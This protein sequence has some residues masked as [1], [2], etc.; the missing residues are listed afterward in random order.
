MIDPRNPN[1]VVQIGATDP[2]TGLPYGQATPVKTTGT[3][4]IPTPQQINGSGNISQGYVN[5]QPQAKDLPPMPDNLYQSARAGIANGTMTPQQAL[6]YLGSYSSQY[7]APDTNKLFA[8]M[9]VNKGGVQYAL[10]TDGSM[11]PITATSTKSDLNLGTGATSITTSTGNPNLDA[12]L[13]KIGGLVGELAAGGQIPTTLQITPALVGKFLAWAHAAV[14]PQTQQLLSAEAGNI[15][16]AIKNAQTQY[17]NTQAGTVQEYGTDLA[18]EQDAA[19]RSGTAFSGQ[20]N[21]NEANL[22]A[23]ANRKLSST[24][25]QSAYDIGSL[26]RGGGADLG[27][28]NASMLTT[29]TESAPGTLSNTG[30]SRGSY[31]PAANSLDFGYNPSAYTAGAIPSNQNTALGNLQSNYLGQYSTL[32]ANNTNGSRSINDLL[33]MITG[34]PAGQSLSI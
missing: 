5:T 28:S 6:A 12:A 8:A 31:T 33:G 7:Q 21:L 18:D 11:K 26:L 20:R 34:V 2:Q 27:S 24:A 14:D 30:G 19:G 1:G 9:T 13:G 4:L 3:S 29:P 17:E 25:S 16:A 22:T 23:S 32:A 10:N 15:N